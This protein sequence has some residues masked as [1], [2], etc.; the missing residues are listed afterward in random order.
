MKA[1]HLI[2]VT[3]LCLVG[4]NALAETIRLSQPV[5]STATSETFGST[6]N[7]ELPKVT[8]ANLMTNSN[9]HMN[10]EFL[11]ETRIAKVCQ[12]KG[13]FFIAQQEEHVVRVS[14]LDY[15]FFLPTDS[16]GKTVTL[17]GKLIEKQMSEEQ[18]AHFK[19]DL[20]DST[21]NSAI[22]AGKVYEIVASSVQV[23]LS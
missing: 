8:L 4:S 6:L 10:N 17:S 7:T 3:I 1:A 22:K 13:C 15:G 5:A 2:L 19:S 9:A 18:A 21:A 11:L 14:F 23:P 20:Q 12:K 16:S